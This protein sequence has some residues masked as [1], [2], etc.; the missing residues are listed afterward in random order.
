MPRLIQLL[1]SST[2]MLLLAGSGLGQAKTEFSATVI[3]ESD[4]KSSQQ[5][6]FVG[7][8][9]M[10]IEPQGAGDQAVVILDFARGISYV[11]MPVQ[12]TYVEVAGLRDD[13]TRQMRFLNIIDPSNPCDALLQPKSGN[14]A[15]KIP[16]K[17]GGSD[18]VNGRA[19]I[20]WIAT[21]S[22]GKQAYVWVDPKLGFLL[23]L[24]AP[25]NKIELQDIR[26]VAQQPELFEVPSGYSRLQIGAAPS[27]TR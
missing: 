8:S 21:V 1:I 6:I 18:T 13:S 7:T 2:L 11:L 9:N 12:K 10:R 25:G 17:Q 23:R 22:E 27:T 16:C 5:R 20:K 4:G 24:D 14:M 19:A 3:Q 26:E 15:T